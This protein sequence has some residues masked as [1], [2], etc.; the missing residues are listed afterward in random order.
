M[1]SVLPGFSGKSSPVYGCYG[2]VFVDV[3]GHVPEAI[4][5][6]F[7]NANLTRSPDWGRE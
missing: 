4:K 6:V 7:P 2:L 1:T 3:P 5:K